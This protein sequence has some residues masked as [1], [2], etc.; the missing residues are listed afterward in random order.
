MRLLTK[1][2]RSL[3]LVSVVVLCSSI[4]S[5]LIARADDYSDIPTFTG[6]ESEYPQEVR[7]FAAKCRELDVYLTLK[8]GNPHP[9]EGTDKYLSDNQG[10]KNACL[11][12]NYCSNDA[13]GPLGNPSGNYKSFCRNAYTLIQPKDCIGVEKIDDA[14]ADLSGGDSSTIIDGRK[15]ALMQTTCLDKGFCKEK[16]DDDEN[17][18]CSKAQEESQKDDKTSKLANELIGDLSNNVCALLNQVTKEGVEKVKQCKEDMANA[19]KQC[20]TDAKNDTKEKLY[21]CVIKDHKLKEKYHLS[22]TLNIDNIKA[23]NQTLNNLDNSAQKKCS[24]AA[25]GFG[26]LWCPGVNVLTSAFDFAVGLITNYLKWTILVDASGNNHLTDNP[27]NIIR[28]TWQNILAIANITLAIAF[29]W[30]LYV[31]MLNSSN[32][33]RAYDAKKLLSRLILVAVA[34]NLSYY[35]CA[36]LADLS[37]IAGVGVYDLI[38]NQLMG[39]GD[40][41]GLNVLAENLTALLLGAPILILVAF[42]TLHL[43]IFFAILTLAALVLR[44]VGLIVLVIASPIAFACYL[45]PNTEKWYKK[46]LTYYLSLLVIF[47]AFTASWAAARFIPNVLARSGNANF[48][49]TL[50]TAPAP[51]LIT[52]PIFKSLG[53]P[54]SNMINSADKFARNSEMGKNFLNRDQRTRDIMKRRIATPVLRTQRNLMSGEG[55]ATRA[56][57]RVYE[58]VGRPFTALRNKLPHNDKPAAK[59]QPSGA[60]TARV[61]ARAIGVATGANLAAKQER[62]DAKLNFAQE[63]LMHSIHKDITNRADAKRSKRVEAASKSYDKTFGNQTSGYHRITGINADQLNQLVS[64]G[65]GANATANKQG[66]DIISYSVDGN[67]I[68]RYMSLSG[69]N[70][71]GAKLSSTDYSAVLDYAKDN[72]LLHNL[73][74]LNTAALS[75][76]A[77]GDTAARQSFVDNFA[78]SPD[79]GLFMT[80]ADQKEFA[81][82]SGKFSPTNMLGTEASMTTAFNKARANYVKNM[83]LADYGNLD[84]GTRTDLVQQIIEGRDSSSLQNLRVKN[85]SFIKNAAELTSMGAINDTS[86]TTHRLTNALVHTRNI[87]T[88]FSSW[89]TTG[90]L[91]GGNNDLWKRVI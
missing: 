50:L 18:D 55:K 4:L 72:G 65:L 28:N 57:S 9:P 17:Y 90:K 61:L 26:W 15:R 86:P 23:I 52:L 59:Q 29:L 35:I 13:V 41:W 74:D 24:D 27:H 11:E 5:P 68:M 87:Q 19:V 38:M 83:S 31:Y 56:V 91:T 14:G 39:N 10:L 71:N 42:C 64:Y 7:D 70:L 6:T 20:A 46:W 66:D 58:T 85:D 22:D 77:N 67:D 49:I 40:P 21:A 88:A 84:S 63:N 43:I 33:L 1:S 73:S 51:I 48:I 47:P 53:G 32:V 81:N 62:A 36:A 76:S 60:K 16:D 69:N 80:K 3:I 79:K 34:M 44:Q 45:L 89:S 8:S 25:K 37:N 30:M 78:S 2:S 82:G 54:L 75:V 12:K